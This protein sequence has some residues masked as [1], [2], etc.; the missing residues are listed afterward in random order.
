M[1][2]GFNSEVS[3]GGL[4]YHVQTEARSG[5][6]ATLDTVVYVSGRVI[7]RVNTSYQDLLDRGASPEE[8]RA[9]VESQHREVV[10]QIE[11]GQVRDTDPPSPAAPLELR[12]L[13]ASSWLRGGSAVVELEVGAADGK[14]AAGAKLEALIESPAGIATSSSGTADASGR[15]VLEFTLPVPMPEGTV[16]I[17]RAALG[18]ARVELRYKLKARPGAPS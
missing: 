2:L 17:L 15:A 8:L 18:N 16:L 5:A 3:A 12:L 4:T 11:S 1:S 7:H 14:P 9:R 6:Q 13:N 10:A